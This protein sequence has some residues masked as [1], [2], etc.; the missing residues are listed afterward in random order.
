VDSAV[1]S[2]LIVDDD[3]HSSRFVAA[4]AERCAF[5]ARVASSAREAWAL[6]DPEPTLI[7]LD[8]HMPDTDGI[9]VLR[10]LASRGIA[11]QIRVFSGSSPGI[12]RS[13]GQI[14]RELGLRMGEPLAK[15]VALE[16]LQALFAEVARIDALDVAKP[17]APP[18]PAVAEPPVTEDELREAI[19]QHHL[20]VVFQPVIELETLTPVGAEALVR[21][22]HPTRGIVPP[23]RFVPLAE[24]SGLV[25]E[26]TELVFSDALAF[27]SRPGY[28]WG[29]KPLSISVNVA[30]AALIESD[31]ARMLAALL[32]ASGV[33]PE[34]LV[35]EV[36][37]SAMH[38]DR[39]GVLE[40]LSRLRLRGVELSIDDFGT[41]TSSLERLDQFPCTELKIDRSF[42]GDLLRRPG[43]EAIVRS[44]IELAQRLGLRTVAE[45]IEDVETLQWLRSARCDKGQ[46][47]FFSRGVEAEDF[48]AWLEGWQPRRDALLEAQPA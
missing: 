46:G 25:I 32:A 18:A 7:L 42:V 5:R 24:R 41:G 14:G 36:T 27:A 29:G 8:L 11:A 6:M 2:V 39:T 33:P 34:R 4:V 20:F 38:A 48:L 45:G 16:G 43:A 23:G 21:W 19:R 28:A 13:A 17:V 9:E 12:L 30:T 31:L 47:F 10:T 22:R 37:E 40:I 3:P 44:T 26:M 1:R 35:V 15:P